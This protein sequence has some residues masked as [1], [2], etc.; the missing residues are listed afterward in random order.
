MNT[1]GSKATALAIAV[2]AAS[3][4]LAL[5]QTLK[6]PDKKLEE[7]IVTGSKIQSGID[8]DVNALPVQVLT[9][10]QFEY[11]PANSIADFL[12]ELPSGGNGNSIFQDE[13]GGGSSS[14]NLRGAGDQ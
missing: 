4:P 3:A 12:H 9:L 2:A 7:V 14:V 5:A 13:G 8:S 6:E 11:T 1:Q 10:E